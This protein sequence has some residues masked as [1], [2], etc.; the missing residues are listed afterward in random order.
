M[1]N[2]FV[3]IAWFILW[4]SCWGLFNSTLAQKGINHQDK[5][6]F[7]IVFFLFLTLIPLFFIKHFFLVNLSLISFQTIFIPLF[8]IFISFP[9]YFFINFHFS[10]KILN[11]RY[12]LSKPF[13]ILFQQLMILLLIF[14]LQ[15]Y[16]SSPF[17]LVVLFGLIFGLIHSPILIFKKNKWGK[18]LFTSSF[19]AG[20]IFPLIII[21]FPAGLLYSFS[22]HWLFYLIIGT[23]YNLKTAKVI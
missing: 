10:Q 17:S 4:F 5:F 19:L 20:L 13:D 22:I 6:Y 11:Y 2:F 12:L 8:F 14:L 16:I 9:I 3:L 15:K 23:I 7:S 1:Q 21:S 18:I